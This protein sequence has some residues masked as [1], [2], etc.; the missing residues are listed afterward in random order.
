[1]L[2]VIAGPTASGKTAVAITLA[3]M[4]NGEVINADSMQVYKGM[5]IGTAKP[6]TEERG[7]IPHHLLDAVNPDEPFSAAQYQRLAKAA[8][9]DIRKRGRVP[10]LVGGTG[11]YINATVYDT[12]FSREDG[13]SAALREYYAALAVEKSAYHIH[14]LLADRDPQSAAI[15]HPC[16]IKRV[17]RALAFCEG[18]GTLFSSH[19][20]NQREKKARVTLPEGI[21][22]IVLDIPRSLLYDRINRRVRVMFDTGLEGEVAGLL[23]AGYSRD[24]P[25]MQGI[26]YKET[27]EYITNGAK[28]DDR[29]SCMESIAQN[30]RRYAKR[31]LTWFRHNAP[32]A[33]WL[34]A[35]D[36]AETVARQIMKG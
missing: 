15:I 32:H 22:F 25:S 20:E 27:V 11:F 36:G 7:G 2:Y 26:G 13:D 4:V 17:A 16:N 29:V 35:E 5:D 28:S 21:R 10:I 9:E 33:E 14:K 34:N 23:A 8:I 18:T 3:R 31:Q 19:N 30:T 1:M 24:L 12:D 6:T